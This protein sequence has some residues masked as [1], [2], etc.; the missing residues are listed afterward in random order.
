MNIPDTIFNESLT[1]LQ[2]GEHPSQIAESYDADY[3]QE[4][5]SLLS[6]AQMGMNIP[7][8]TPP[9]PYK[10]YRFKEVA[11]SPFTRLFE[12]LSM[13]R[14]A[15]VPISLV[16]VLLGVPIITSATKNS[17]PGDKLYS[18]KRASE[19]V[20]LTLTQD[21][22]KF[23]NLHVELMQKRLEE[24]KQAADSGDAESETLAIAELQSQTEKTFAEA[25][26]VATANAISNQDSSLLDNLVAVNK[27]QKSVLTELSE[28]SS[29]S[30]DTQ[31]IATTALLDS[32]KNDQTLAKIIATVNDQVL[33]DNPNKVSVT[34]SISSNYSNRITI[35][36]NIFTVD[37]STVITNLDGTT[38][39]DV[40]AVIGRAT[41]IG[42]HTESGILLAKQ[43]SLLPDDGS[44]KGDATV[45][46]KPTY[47]TT[48]PVTKPEP[49]E[50]LVEGQ[51]PEEDPTKVQGTFITE[52]TD[53]QFAP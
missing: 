5:A 35:E 45:L 19:Q 32:R 44:V 17:I 51:L 7:K 39:T 11:V 23:A 13:F 42:T 10:A 1:R 24:V 14:L 27:E 18:L 2:N 53:P 38:I 25:G 12:I 15:A 52:P 30:T 16:I 31:M 3:Q 33:A 34:G 41:I 21:Q 46:V 29:S 37:E 48:K 22:N 50:P 47:T 8:V 20:Q 49:L 6:V 26:P 28:D 43:I 40:N 4:L 36:K 9:T